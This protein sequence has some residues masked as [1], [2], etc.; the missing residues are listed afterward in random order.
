M[1]RVGIVG[2]PNAG[3]STLFNA[4]TRS[5]QA[6]VASYPFCTIEPNVGV[7]E[8]P[9]ERLERLVPIYGSAKKIS[10][11]VEFF[12]IAGLVRGASKGEGLGNRFLANIREVDAIVE[13]VRCFEQ[14]DVSH[15]DGDLDPTRDAETIRT[16]LAL[17]DL[18]TIERRKGKIAK[19]ALAGDKTA[20]ATTEVLDCLESAINEKQTVRGLEL[21]AAQ[22]ELVG[23]LFLLTGKP[24]IYAANVS[25]SDLGGGNACADKLRERVAANEAEVVEICAELEAELADLADDEAAEYMEAVGLTTT[26][27]AELIRSAY[28]I[29][30]LITFFTGNEKEVRARAI[31]RGTTA[32]DAAGHVHSDIARGFIGAEVIAY[33]LLIREESI[34]HAREDG[35]LRLEGKDYEVHDGDVVFFRFHV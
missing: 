8:V 29:L 33:D 34:H 28:R 17:A 3:K 22:A 18:E 31:P 5:H 14:Q 16:E 10:A 4:L 30:G 9:D 12:D 25:E 2:L 24:I 11:A 19:L 35:R 6:P 1:L 7:I 32:L 23:D 15:V 21:S 13:V 20:R 26:G 27:T